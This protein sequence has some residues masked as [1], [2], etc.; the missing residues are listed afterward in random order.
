M[1]QLNL[2]ERHLLKISQQHKSIMVEI[3]DR[4]TRIAGAIASHS[5]IVAGNTVCITV[6]SAVCVVAR[7]F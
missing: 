2:A 1:E 3:H 4:E 6:A 7:L 5:T